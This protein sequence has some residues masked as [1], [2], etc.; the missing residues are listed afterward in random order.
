[1]TAFIFQ[2]INFLIL[3]GVV[4]F[5]AKKLLD[6]YFQKQRNDLQ[7][8]MQLA[9]ADLEKIQHEYEQMQE[10]LNRLEADLEQARA[11]AESTIQNEATKLRTETDGFISKLS[12]DLQMKFDQETERAKTA[13]KEKLTDEAFR[14]ARESLSAR[15]MKEDEAWTTQLVQ[16]QLPLGKTNYASK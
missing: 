10:K 16:D 5:F 9:A 3:V 11:D 4:G 15:L 1:M 12:R 2:V 13:F 8:Q 14:M 6:R 7:N